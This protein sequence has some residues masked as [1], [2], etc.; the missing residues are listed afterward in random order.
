MPLQGSLGYQWSA[1]C[2]VS[3][4]YRMIAALSGRQ[5]EPSCSTGTQHA[6][7]ALFAG[8]PRGAI[9]AARASHPRVR[10]TVQ[11]PYEREALAL[12]PGLTCSAGILPSGL[13]A[14]KGGLRWSPLLMTV[15]TSSYGTPAA[16]R[17][18]T[19]EGSWGKG[20][21][22][23]TQC[24]LQ[25]MTCSRLPQGRC[26]W[27]GVRHWYPRNGR[28]AGGLQRTQA[29]PCRGLRILRPLPCRR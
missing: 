8:R 12:G 23:G 4:R 2:R 7:P 11:A 10:G 20:A 21:A 6:R 13:I 28:N 29:V 14:R 27:Q 24:M 26:Q 22:A 16:L 5:N 3:H 1:T 25:S 19:R 9:C 18:G 17:R 15:R